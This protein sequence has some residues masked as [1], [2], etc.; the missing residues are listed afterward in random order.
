M[1]G[2]PHSAILSGAVNFVLELALHR[3]FEAVEQSHIIV[4]NQYAL[5]H[6]ELLY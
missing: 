6:L 5:V 4:N 3:S 2:N 1:A